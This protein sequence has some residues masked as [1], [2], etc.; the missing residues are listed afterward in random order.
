M[1]HVGWMVVDDPSVGSSPSS[2][3]APSTFGG[4]STGQWFIHQSVVHPRVVVHP[5]MVDRWANDFFG[6][7]WGMCRVEL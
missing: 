5:R 6:G 3:P 4:P 7:K 1:S 2:G